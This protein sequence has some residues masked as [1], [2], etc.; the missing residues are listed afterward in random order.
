MKQTFIT[1]SYGYQNDELCKILQKSISTFSNNQLKIYTV[2]DFD[3]NYNYENPNFWKSGY[4]YVMKIETCLK[5]LKE[6][7]Q[8]VW[9]DTDIVVNERIDTIWEKFDSLDDY[10]LLPRHRF[11][12]YVQNPV[13]KTRD[14]K[15]KMYYDDI[16]DYFEL[17]ENNMLSFQ[18]SVL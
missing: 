12:N 17:P 1:F 14:E 5:A 18:F 15:M 7:D 10:P 6:F 8:I 11:Y 13:A 3:F 9:L 4:G 2:D 16:L